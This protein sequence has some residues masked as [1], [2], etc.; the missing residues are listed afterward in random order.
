MERM[1]RKQ[2]YIEPRQD[3]LLKERSRRYRV[4]EADLIRRALD[5]GLE[6]GTTSAPNPEAWREI[7]KYIARR[8]KGAGASPRGRRHRRRWTREKL[9]DR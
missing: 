3:R 7:E 4:T 5:K 2:V 6:A 9:Y 8:V 1:I